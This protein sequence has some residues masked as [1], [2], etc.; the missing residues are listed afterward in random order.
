MQDASGAHHRLARSQEEAAEL[1]SRLQS[2]ESGG[3]GLG[4]LLGRL[5][6]PVKRAVRRVLRPQ[7]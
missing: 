7:S 3:S 4:S 6:W 5:L 2:L 1:H